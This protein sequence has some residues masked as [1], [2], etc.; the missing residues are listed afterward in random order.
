MLGK[1]GVPVT[2][3]I[4]NTKA[5]NNVAYIHTCAHCKWYY[6]VYWCTTVMIIVTFS[7]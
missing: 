6:L 5:L 2:V 4:D 3:F 7:L 1:G